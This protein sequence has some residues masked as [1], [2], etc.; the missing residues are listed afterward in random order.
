MY[1]EPTSVRGLPSLFLLQPRCHCAQPIARGSMRIVKADLS[2]ACGDPP[3]AFEHDGCSGCSGVLPARIG[4]GEGRSRSRRPSARCRQPDPSDVDRGGPVALPNRADV[5]FHAP[6]SPALLDRAAGRS[7]PG[8]PQAIRTGRRG[9]VA[10]R[11][12]VDSEQRRW[13]YAGRDDRMT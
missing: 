10:A 13:R 12:R 2:K 9:G 8:V 7:R 3:S 4:T 1:C 11:Q 5:A 6:R